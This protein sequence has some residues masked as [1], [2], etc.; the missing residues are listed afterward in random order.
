MNATELINSLGAA[1]AWFN[2]LPDGIKQTLIGAAGEI[3]ASVAQGVFA[4]ARQRLRSLLQRGLTDDAVTSAI[5]SALQTALVAT[6]A[7]LT[8]N[9]D[10]YDFYLRTLF[11]P[12]LRQPAVQAEFA[13]LVAPMP[14]LT[15]DIDVL[16]AEFAA[17]DDHDPDGLNAPFAN[18]L[19]DL[20]GQFQNAAAWQ[21]ELQPVIAIRNERTLQDLLRK[22]A[23]L[24]LDALI[25]TNYLAGVLD[26]A[27]T[28]LLER[29]KKDDPN[30]RLPAPSLQRVFVDLR[31]DREP[32]LDRFMA[33]L[34]ID[35]WR[36]TDVEESLR[37][38]CTADP[39]GQRR[40]TLLRTAGAEWDA[41]RWA[42]A[43]RTLDEE[44]LAD[45]AQR[46][47]VAAAEIVP[48][49]AL[50]TPLEL[51]TTLERPQLVLLGEPGGGKSTITRR[52]AGVLA[53]LGQ[54]APEPLLDD[55]E[56]IWVD[57]LAATF[58]RWLL[59]VRVVMSRWA[60]R[61]P[62]RPGIADD[63]IAECVHL[64]QQTCSQAGG[65]LAENVA[66][67][68]VGDAPTVCVLLDGLDEVTDPAQRAT[69][70]GAIRDFCTKYKAVPL[71]I[72]C[73]SRPYR[74]L[75][76]E[77][78]R[79]RQGWFDLPE[80][81]LQPLTRDAQELFVARWHDEME[82]IHRYEPAPAQRARR[83]MRN[84]LADTRR[85]ELHE[86]AGTPLLLT[87]MVIV[88]YTEGLP[89]SRAQLYE[90]LVQ[91]LLFEW[92]RIR[93]NA[94]GQ[95]A[96]LDL[97]LTANDIQKADLETRLNELA[98]AIHDPAQSRDTVDIPEHR[99]LAAL[100]RA[101]AA[102]LAD[103]ATNRAATDWALQVLHLISTRSGLI[104]EVDIASDGPAVRREEATYQFVHRTF[105]EYLAARWLATAEDEV[106]GDDISYA[107]I[108][109]RVDQ[110]EWREAI[111]LAIGYL[112]AV[113]PRATE[114]TG[115]LL[116]GLW[117]DLDRTPALWPRTLLLSEA[118]IHLLGEKRLGRVRNP[119]VREDLQTWAQRDLRRIMQ[120]RRRE[121]QD[122]L[123]AG[124]LLDDL[125]VLP[126]GLDDFLPVPGAGFRI[127]K[128][129][130]TNAQFRR[131]VRAG[132]YGENG[133]RRPDWWSE[134]G[135]KQRQQRDWTEP[136]YWDDRQFNRDTQPVV[137]VSWYEAEAYCAWLNL[138]A[139]GQEYKPDGMLAQ[140][141]TREQWMQAARNGR[142][143]P[144][145]QEEDYPWRAPF[146]KA[147]ANTKESNLQ[148][149]TP[150]AMYPDGAPFGVFDL[151]GNV[152]EWTADLDKDGYPY[153]KGGS[154]YYIAEWAR[155]SAAV[156][157]FVVWDR[158]VYVGFRLV[159][160]P[161][162]HG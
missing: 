19:A 49:T 154:W 22:L 150:V 142:P 34:G 135:W 113:L 117:P 56:R 137:G 129:P 79:K 64:V 59:P 13:K 52:M 47:L 92:E 116:H 114:R 38:V 127:G 8:Q 126:E 101:Y 153:R 87:M 100:K 145:K 151:A 30:D 36:R 15:P 133:G 33:R 2:S 37:T 71:L 105:Q 25:R 50:L 85:T 123:Q 51:L 134:A 141:P 97:L 12:W 24:D 84:A 1:G 148:Q 130:V 21:G 90:Q 7:P 103:F 88:N 138:T 118:L 17:V 41:A 76:A 95:Q 75:R 96:G 125:G 70:I 44:R 26:D 69:L 42:D 156:N 20:V 39:A 108:E 162:S 32:T 4:A 102:D 120:D 107:L 80:A 109:E 62:A 6:L 48:A 112:A 155:A 81:T 77:A 159:C 98:F 104:N 136:R 149:T 53:K 86:M 10:E 78:G 63:L 73:R 106:S 35:A 82:A 66:D 122:R 161:I 43:V 152:W 124:L 45:L 60:Q 54:P 61:V 83:D 160:V 31:V 93:L 27:E 29:G 89:D 58:G 72:T 68:F 157:W 132:G 128:Y 99:L 158:S 91:Q 110:T 140:L 11:G 74:A 46:L 67:R 94:S 3:G 111:L 143:A 121:A 115:N 55:F 40:N 147:L 18:I 23:P 14:N 144:A 146:D 9:Q 28:V 139:E 131:F 119:K 16:R 57:Q 5:A 65:R